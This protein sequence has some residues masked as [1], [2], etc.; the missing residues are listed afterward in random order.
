MMAGI[1]T[2]IGTYSRLAAALVAGAA[3]WG[4]PVLAWSLTL[5]QAADLAVKSYP[6][7][8]AAEEFGKA[9]DQKVQ[10]AYA[11]Y[12][13]RMDFT[14]GYGS[15][16]ADN[17]TTRAANSAAG[18]TQHDLGLNRGEGS[19]VVKQNLFD[20]ADV[21]SKVA[22]A[23]AQLQ[24]AQARLQ[25]T[26][27]AVAL[28]A[29]Q[30]YVEMVIKYIQLESI[31][32]NVQLHQHIMAKVQKKFEA[33]AGSEADVEQAKSRTLLAS[34]NQASNQAAYKNTQ[35]KFKEI[36]GLPP[37]TA[38]EMV[39]PVAPEA[40]L[41]KSLEEAWNRT[42]LDNKELEAARFA[43][44]AAESGLAVAQAAL[45]PKVEMELTGSNTANVSGSAGH[46]Q[47]LTAMLRMNHNLYN[48]GADLSKLEEQQ[49]LLTQAQLNLEKG[50]LTLKQAVQESW[51]RLA[52]AK[53]RIHFMRRHYE[54]SK[55]VTTSYHQQFK[56][57]K[58][59]LLDLLNS[60]NEL[61][62]AKNGLLLEE[63]NHIK[64]AYELFGRMGTLREVLTATAGQAGV[65]KIELERDL[66]LKRLQSEEVAVEPD[67]LH[68]EAVRPTAPANPDVVALPQP[69]VA[70]QP[71]VQ[72]KA[73]VGS[74]KPAEGVWVKEVWIASQVGSGAAS[75]PEEMT[76]I[77]DSYVGKRVTDSD[78][79]AL[80]KRLTLLYEGKGLA[81]SQPIVV[82]QPTPEGVVLVRIPEY[83]SHG[84]PEGQETPSR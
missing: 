62:A 84:N 34:A 16:T 70:A 13:P 7:V 59:T 6:D 40:L 9:L 31:K 72:G 2:S 49:N 41:P 71:V 25:L 44:A 46:S 18:R 48:G 8:L 15:E 24:A 32:D 68:P 60:E 51:N 52:M 73:D 5:Q 19:L 39:M 75:F 38:E 21:R 54:V 76:K 77:T 81:A 45:Y 58:R 36:V 42:M 79:Q 29:V 66:G 23:K 61:F 27:D 30:T 50:R 17:A 28:L 63:L 80:K 10:Q 57:G 20:G 83:R 55:Q 37:L 43:V 4:V 53:D 12:L 69:A 33:G 1:L 74:A 11:G 14:V 64:G 65:Q 56:A 82:S 67:V 22:Q 35:A 26:S 47:T 78:L 3:F